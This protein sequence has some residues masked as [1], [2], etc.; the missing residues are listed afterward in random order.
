MTVHLVVFVHGITPERRPTSRESMYEAFWEAMVC[1]Q[2]E[3]DH[4]I[5]QHS[6]VEWGFAA[7]AAERSDTRLAAAEA[8]IGQTVDYD[9][10]ARHRGPNNVLHTGAFGDWNLV[11]GLRPLVRRL[12]Q[13]L[14]QLGLADAIYYT[15]AEGETAVRS[16]VYAQVLQELRPYREHGDVSLHIVGHSLGVTVSH[17]FLFGLF[18]KQTE[19]DFLAQ[20]PSEQDRQDYAFWRHKARSGELRVGTFVSMASQLPLFALRKQ[21]L[22]DHLARQGTLDPSVIGIRDEAKVRWLVLYDVDDVL[23]FATREL[24][25]NSNAIRQVQVDVGDTPIHA[26]TRYWTNPEVIAETAA[27]LELNARSDGG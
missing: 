10:V 26:H 9:N 22:V 11:P 14:L 24:Y 6:F 12:R 21:H 18:G 7:G 20:S 13:E 8:H 19:P 2:P 1:K 4:L 16:T 15:S 23:G 17:D 5:S 3:L 25:G 27:L